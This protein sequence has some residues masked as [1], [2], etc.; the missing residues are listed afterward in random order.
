M[1]E[2]AVPQNYFLIF[3]GT[4]AIALDK[5]HITFGRSHD[6]V[7]IVDDPRVSRHHMEIR[8]IRDHF[9]VFDLNSSGGTYVNGQRVNQGILYQDDLISLAGVNFIFTNDLKAPSG[10]T[11]PI[12]PAGPGL[13][14]TA[15]LTTG[16]LK[17]H[18]KKYGW[19]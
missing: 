14:K 17:M 7:V 4:M 3:E 6:N 13:H 11:N 9:V 12:S 19:R 8:V 16:S 2:F 15:I 10:D 5:P 1:N 18:D